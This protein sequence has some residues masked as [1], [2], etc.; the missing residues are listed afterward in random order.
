MLD[1]PSTAQEKQLSF[2]LRPFSAPFPSLSERASASERATN[3]NL[4]SAFPKMSAAAAAAADTLP[5]RFAVAVAE[6]QPKYAEEIRRSLVGVPKLPSHPPP[7]LTPFDGWRQLRH[8]VLHPKEV[9][10]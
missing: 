1:T 2:D 6:L 4:N 5:Q 8:S 7:I 3:H 10:N 9:R